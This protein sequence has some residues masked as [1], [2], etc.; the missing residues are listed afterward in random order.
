MRV[1][2]IEVR[3]DRK[4]APRSDLEDEVVKG[5]R[6][7]ILIEALGLSDDQS[8]DCIEDPDSFQLSERSFLDA[9]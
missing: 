9:E 7:I 2:A 5:E 3:D 6:R 4:G 8:N 1:S